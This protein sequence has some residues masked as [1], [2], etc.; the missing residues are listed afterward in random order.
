MPVFAEALL[1]IIRAISADADLPDGWSAHLPTYCSLEL[2]PHKEF[3][4]VSAPSG[5]L[6]VSLI[7]SGLVRS[8]LVEGHFSAK[9]IDA[10]IRALKGET[11]VPKPTAFADLMKGQEAQAAQSQTSYQ[12]TKSEIRPTGAAHG[13]VGSTRDPN[14]PPGFEDEHRITAASHAPNFGIK[15]DPDADLYPPGGK[16]PQLGPLG[17][18]G[19]SSSSNP[20]TLIGPSG[21][22]RGPSTAPGRGMHPEPF[23][24]SNSPFI[25]YDPTSPF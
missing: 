16:Y 24:S 19:P 2:E 8:Y 13:F 12:P 15:F 11:A 3:V 18:I 7:D 17:P 6:L 4:A 23:G 22:F 10:C 14:A 21:E 25:R 5:K 9:S 20:H 1:R